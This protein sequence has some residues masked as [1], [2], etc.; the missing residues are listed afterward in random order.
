MR[1]WS[2]GVNSLHKTASIYLDEAPFYIFFLDWLANVL[3]E[4]IPT[5]PLPKIRMRL[6]DPE[7]IEC[8]GGE[9]WTTLDEWYGDW[10]QAFHLFVHMPVFDFCTRKT[11]DECIPIGY[12]KLRKIFYER[13]KE[14]W[15]DIEKEEK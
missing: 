15:D 10:S 12:K 9:K 13:D 14:Y 11:K 5:I 4:L 6:K 1:S 2:Y 8:N 7:D 3:C